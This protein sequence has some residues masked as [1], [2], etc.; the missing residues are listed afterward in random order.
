[1]AFGIDLLFQSRLHQESKQLEKF[2]LPQT[3]LFTD[4]NWTLDHDER[5]A[6]QF[7]IW[8]VNKD[9]FIDANEV[10][11]VCDSTCSIPREAGASD[12]KM[13]RVFVLSF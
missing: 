7:F 10:R 12:M 1:M 6:K 13:T 2:N 3:L 9:G 5:F 4:G 8:D 11:C